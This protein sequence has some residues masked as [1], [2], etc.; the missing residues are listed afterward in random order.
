MENNKGYRIEREMMK[1]FKGKK[2]SA[3]CVDFQTT[4]ALYEVKSCQLFVECNNGNHRRSYVN[5]P[6][7]KI[8][9]TQLGRF[10][11]KLENH[12]LLKVIARKEN[13]IPKYIFI[14][15]IG[16]Q[17]V[18]RVKTWNEIN[19]LMLKIKDRTTVRIKDIFNENWEDE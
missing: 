1:W 16:K 4:K 17:K 10:Y 8:I 7:K 3:D 5:K 13:K 2:H 19:T 14:L 15:M 6:H 11:V 9:T 12:K 18:W